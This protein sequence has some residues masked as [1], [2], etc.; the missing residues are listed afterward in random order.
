MTFD[1][2]RIHTALIADTC[3][4]W[5]VLSAQRLYAAARSAN[6]QFAITPMVLYECLQKPRKHRT[7]ETTE[8]Q[9][10]L[11]EA[12]ARGSFAL[13]S[14]SLDDLLTVSR[15]AP[16]G[17]SSGEL[18]CIAV[19]VAGTNGTFMTD[20][21]Q[22]RHHAHERLRLDVETTPRLYGWLHFHRHLTDGDHGDVLLEHQKFERRPLT[23]FLE[24][25]YMSALQYR[26]MG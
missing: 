15:G 9:R 13:V 2:R 20:E 10:R 11:T 8:M 4:V 24:E 19:A 23:K 25:A 14:C 6:V 7:A 26:L 3:S 17:L 21:R 18:S 5:H 22:A 12:R 1:P 16:I